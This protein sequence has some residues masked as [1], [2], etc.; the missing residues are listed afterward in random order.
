MKGERTMRLKVG[1]NVENKTDHKTDWD[2]WLDLILVFFVV[3]MIGWIWEVLLIWVQSGDLTNRG[4]LHGPWLER[5]PGKWW[6]FFLSSMAACGVVEYV[7]SWV[8]EKVYHTR[9]WDYTN[10]PLNLNGRIC[11]SGLLVFGLGGLL[12]VYVLYP[13]LKKLF[14]QI[15]QHTK[16]V[17]VACLGAL[18]CIDAVSSLCSPNML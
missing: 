6:V 14:S 5:L 2:Y 16:T 17:I 9:W 1:S 18:F 3:S 8:L 4:V 7:V 15:P 11:L 13:R 10:M 12:L